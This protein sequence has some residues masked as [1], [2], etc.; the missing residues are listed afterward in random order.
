[1]VLGAKTLTPQLVE[2]TLNLLLKVS[3]DLDLAREHRKDL[4]S[5]PK[6]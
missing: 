4:F 3:G 2:D 6:A 1:V 5:F